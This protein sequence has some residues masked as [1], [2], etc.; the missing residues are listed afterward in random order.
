MNKS[1]FSS[2][3]LVGLNGYSSVKRE[4]NLLIPISLETLKRES[5][6]SPPKKNQRRRKTGSLPPRSHRT[7]SRLR[8]QRSSP[9]RT[10][11]R[12]LV[13]CTKERS[14]KPDQQ[15]TGCLSRAKENLIPSPQR[16]RGIPRGRSASCNVSVKPG[17]CSYGMILS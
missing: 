4:S 2:S 3:N 11:P 7:T 15:T 9:A 6:K 13:R 16:G 1:L 8:E 5:P 17:A 14:K 12:E 10:T